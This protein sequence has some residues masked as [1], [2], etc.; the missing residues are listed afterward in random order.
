M[1]S[2]VGAGRV[3]PVVTAGLMSTIATGGAQG[4][5]GRRW[6]CLVALVAQVV[7]SWVMVVL[8]ALVVG[9]W[10]RGGDSGAGGDRVAQ[11]CCRC[12][13]LVALV[14]LAARAV[15]GCRVRRA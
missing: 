12:G 1:A 10:R 7:S 5:Q 9:R 4:V 13:E 3:A 15:L 8:V 6:W 11:G 14:E 2:L